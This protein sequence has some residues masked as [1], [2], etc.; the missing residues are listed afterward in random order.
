MFSKEDLAKY[1]A[2]KVLMDSASYNVKGEAAPMVASL[3][4][5]YAGLEKK[6]AENIECAPKPMK[7]VGV[8]KPNG[9]VD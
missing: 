7:P 8:P 2:F 9:K 1:R 4:A 3:F 5:W 6:I